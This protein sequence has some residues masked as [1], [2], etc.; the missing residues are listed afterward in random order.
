VKFSILPHIYL[1]SRLDI[2]NYIELSGGINHRGDKKRIYVVKADG[3]VVLPTRSGWFKHRRASIA[4]LDVDRR[5]ALT[6]WG[7]TSAIIYQL[8]LGAA[9]VNS[10]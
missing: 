4:P 9:A 6:I 5:R 10:F 2:T 1:I 8:A 3:S 7:E